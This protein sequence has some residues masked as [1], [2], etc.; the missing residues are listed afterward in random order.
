MSRSERTQTAILDAALAALEENPRE[1]NVR[2][3]AQIAGV[4]RQAVYLHFAGRAA[5]L[6]A[7]ARH[8]DDRLDLSQRV[9][10][11]AAA[12]TAD[13][14]LARYAGFVADYNPLL[15]AVARAADAA[16][17]SDP[18]VAAA[19]ADRLQQRR[20]GG[21]QVAN[22]L[23]GWG[24]L[25]PQWTV[26]A[27]GDW[28]TVQASVKVWEE[29]VLD[30]G[31]SRDRFATMLAT[32]CTRALLVP[33]AASTAA[34]RLSSTSGSRSLAGGGRRAPTRLRHTGNRR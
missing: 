15:Y 12:E 27:A 28:L 25:A 29:L 9:E 6:I 21:Y 34:R 5:L 13:D 24:R 18:D 26:R 3:V 20:R 4:S 2:R 16:R 17:R 7:V 30:L 11:I 1:V 10:L 23:A 14:L 33:A 32:A 19:W 22:R 8:V 31:W